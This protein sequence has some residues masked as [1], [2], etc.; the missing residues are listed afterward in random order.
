MGNIQNT[1]RPIVHLPQAEFLDGLKINTL[2]GGSF[3][4]DHSDMMPDKDNAFYVGGASAIYNYN[5][6]RGSSILLPAS[7]IVGAFGVGACSA[8]NQLS[9]LGGV[10]RQTASAGTTTTITTTQNIVKN[11]KGVELRV[12]G[13]TG[14]GYQGTIK[15]NTIGANSLLTLVTAGTFDATTVFQIFAGSLWVFIGGATNGLGVYDK[16]TNV[17]TQKATTGIASA[18]STD[19]QLIATN[20][21]ASNSGVVFESGTISAVASLVLTTNLNLTANQRKYFRLVITSGT[22]AGQSALITAHGTGASST[23]TTEPFVISP[24]TTSKFQIEGNG[25]D[26]GTAAAG[27]TTTLTVAASKVLVLN[28]FANSQIRIISGTGTGQIKPIASN[29]AGA[30]GVITFSSA[31]TI[32]SD[33]SS[34][35]VIEADDNALYLAGNNATPFW[36][37]SMTGNTWA[38]LAARP[39]AQ[40]SGGTLSFIDSVKDTDWNDGTYPILT[41]SLVKQNGRYIYSFTG[42]A[43]NTL[44]VFDIALNAW[45]LLAYGN[46]TD[47][48]TAGTSAV[49]VNGQIFIMKEATQYIY[50]FNVARNILDPFLYVPIPQST[51]VNGNK[52]VIQNY[53]EGSNSLYWL[54]VLAHSKPDITRYLLLD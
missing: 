42:G 54:Y 33:A 46:Q 30:S 4:G 34:V 39:V 19:G 36:K 44:Y 35:Y 32:A 22:G 41:G 21:R 6:K 2:A 37:Y 47:T 1:L 23:I 52:L 18:W 26:N 16:A 51:T 31:M 3:V 48:F 28:Q 45:T 17:W 15:S 13:G 11:L 38:S 10:D 24:D 43:T 20:G 49:D 5:A 27:S 8:F 12:I 7:A 9:M 50:K 29:T 53:K 40:G 25:F 14:I